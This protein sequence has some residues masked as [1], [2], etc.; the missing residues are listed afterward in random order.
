MVSLY[1]SNY[2]WT[3][4]NSFLE[5]RAGPNFPIG[6]FAEKGLPDA[7][8][9]DIAKPPG[10]ATAGINFSAAAGHFI[11]RQAGVMLTVS[12]SRNKQ[13][14]SAFRDE[15]LKIVPNHVVTVNTKHW[16]TTSVLGGVF[17]EDHFTSVEKLSWRLNIQAGIAF[18]IVPGYSY[19]VFD[20]RTTFST[21]VNSN[22]R[23][24]PGSFA[25]AA[26]GSLRYGIG[27]I[28]YVHLT[29][30]YFNS[31]P[32]RKF[33]YNPNF[34]DSGSADVTQ[35]RPQNAVSVLTGIGVLIR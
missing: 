16:S 2:A 27:K 10:A 8:S 15:L 26:G 1:F 21:T 12:N 28:W 35:K 7:I 34:P 33:S 13:D 23:T 30:Q 29:G 11:T 24:L 31:T 32:K 6:K 4:E 18:T 20:P 19:V 14:A 3:Q 17:I 22:K 9:A 25:F 5:L